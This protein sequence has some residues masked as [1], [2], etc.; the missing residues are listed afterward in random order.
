[1][2]EQPWPFR[3][4]NW[5]GLRCLLRW[6][7]S[8]VRNLQDSACCIECRDCGAVFFCVES[9][10]AKPPGKEKAPMT[11]RRGCANE[12][13]LKAPKGFDGNDP[14]DLPPRQPEITR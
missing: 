13:G 1:M 10:R 14:L 9:M 8:Q 12:H 11:E 4:T 2:N 5:F 6:C 3:R 7:P